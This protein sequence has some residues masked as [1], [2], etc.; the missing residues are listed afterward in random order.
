MPWIFHE[1]SNS[2]W[3][4]L[5]SK[6]TIPRPCRQRETMCTRRWNSTFETHGPSYD[7]MSGILST[8]PCISSKLAA[9]WVLSSCLFEESGHPTASCSDRRWR[10]VIVCRAMCLVSYYGLGLWYTKRSDER[11][12]LRMGASF[13]RV[14]PG[15]FQ[16]AIHMDR[17]P[18]LPWTRWRFFFSVRGL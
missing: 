12:R 11:T 9:E 14:C 5:T 6:K 1:L 7:A 17:H 16:V 10:H 13:T 4:E 15:T 2:L 3:R 8:T 18:F